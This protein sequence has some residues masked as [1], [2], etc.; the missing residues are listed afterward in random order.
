[1]KGQPVF[2]PFA[3]G[4]RIEEL[5]RRKCS[6]RLEIFSLGDAP[7]CLIFFDENL[8]VTQTEEET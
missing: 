1:M 3:Q 6:S 2:T 5:D 8:S 7:Q 4:T